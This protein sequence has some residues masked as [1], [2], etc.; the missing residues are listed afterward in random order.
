MADRPVLAEA[1]R[2]RLELGITQCEVVRLK[3]Q[4][5]QTQLEQTTAAVNAG[6][7]AASR[8]GF[9]LQRQSPDTWVYV[10]AGAGIGDHSG[11]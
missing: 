5:L 3:L 8:P 6:L 10:P 9:D 1:D 7:Q 4:V 11:R 2:L